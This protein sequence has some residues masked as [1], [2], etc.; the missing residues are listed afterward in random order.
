MALIFN[1]FQT[2]VM[3]LLLTWKNIDQRS[4]YQKTYSGNRRRNITDFIA[5]LASVIGQLTTD[6][7]E[8]T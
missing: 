5:F 1:P 3:T 2:M 4:V 6:F 7:I 8:H